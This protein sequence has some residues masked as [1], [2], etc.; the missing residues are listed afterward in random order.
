[1]HGLHR[2]LGALQGEWLAEGGI[3]GLEVGP[4]NFRKVQSFK[5]LIK[6]KIRLN[7][8]LKMSF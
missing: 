8:I 2:L 5:D 7:M 6:L 4:F 3:N 1:M